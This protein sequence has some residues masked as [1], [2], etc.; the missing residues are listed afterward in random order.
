MKKGGRNPPPLFCPPSFLISEGFSRT[1]FS[2]R[3]LSLSF[4]VVLSL[5]ENGSPFFC[6][7]N[8]WVSITS[9]YLCVCACVQG[10]YCLGGFQALEKS[11][12][13]T[14][15]WGS[16]GEKLS[17]FWGGGGWRVRVRLKYGLGLL[18]TFQQLALTV[19]TTLLKT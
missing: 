18:L 6:Q 8:A 4:P 19:K 2:F 5:S 11:C 9:I 15:F 14:I 1:F 10:F 13:R 12:T 17:F 16:L 7:E 3:S